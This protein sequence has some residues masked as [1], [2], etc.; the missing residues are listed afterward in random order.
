[1]YVRDMESRIELTLDDAT[2]NRCHELLKS[3]KKLA[4]MQKDNQTIDRVLR[5]QF[6]SGEH[7]LI[8]DKPYLVYDIET[9]YGTNNLRD[10]EFLIAY[11]IDS[12][13]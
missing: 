8:Q 9:T 11:V 3:D 6:V 10:F 1:M 4:R 12:A 7:R 13:P 5:D 2:I